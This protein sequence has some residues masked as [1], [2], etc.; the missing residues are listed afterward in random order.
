MYHAVSVDLHCIAIPISS[1]FYFVIS[2]YCP[3]L[4]VVPRNLSTS[5]CRSLL[6]SPSRRSR[7]SAA[8]YGSTRVA[9]KGRGRK[10]AKTPPA[11]PSPGNSGKVSKWGMWET[12]VY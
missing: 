11:G 2:S 8:T 12:T 1:L 6:N 5:G 10:D 3:M 4:F 9:I 7:C